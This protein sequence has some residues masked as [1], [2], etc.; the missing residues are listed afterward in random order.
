MVVFIKSIKWHQSMSV[1]VILVHRKLVCGA[2][3]GGD[4]RV[5]T[6]QQQRYPRFSWWLLW[7]PS[8]G[9]LESRR[10]R[11]GGDCCWVEKKNH[12]CL[13][14]LGKLFNSKLYLYPGLVGRTEDSNACK[15]WGPVC[16][17]AQSLVT[18]TISLFSTMI[19]SP[20]YNTWHVFA[21]S[22]FG[23]WM[24]SFIIPSANGCLWTFLRF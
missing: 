4:I 23:E 13:Y 3:V 5:S 11:T 18:V 1:L 8:F 21:Q 14:V 9:A 2:R 17:C 6:K 19:S 10:L 15:P 12:S 24:K 22:M 20:L 7:L 16:V